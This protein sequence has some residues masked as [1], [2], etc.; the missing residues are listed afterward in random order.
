MELRRLRYFLVLA[1]EGHFGRAAR[2]LGIAQSALSQQIQVPERELDAQLLDR[3]SRQVTLTPAGE[4]LRRTAAGIL[5]DVER[6]VEETRAVARG[7]AGTL[8]IGHTRSAPDGAA[9]AIVAEFRRRYP[10]VDVT[11]ITGYTGRNVADLN[12]GSLDAAF[13]RPPLAASS[14]LNC[15]VVEREPLVVGLPVDHELSAQD[16]VLAEQIIGERIIGWPEANAPGLYQYV[17]EIL[18]GGVGPEV[19]V[20][21]PDEEHMARAVARGEGIAICFERKLRAIRVPGFVLRPFRPPVPMADLAL[22][23]R[24]GTGVYALPRLVS[25]A[26]R[27]SAELA[28][29]ALRIYLQGHPGVPLFSGHG[30]QHQC[31]QYPCDDQRGRHRRQWRHG[32]G[33]RRRQRRTVPGVTSR[34]IRSRGGRSRISAAR[35]ARSAQSSRGRGLA[36]R[37]TATSCRSTSSS[38]SLEAVGRA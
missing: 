11:L 23:W 24:D 27:W 29:L 32:E 34:C 21:E 5:R 7:R 13:V 20:E 38:A 33:Q 3:S 35:T 14:G 6:A 19:S 18:W 36:W 16:D 28:G 8:R 12:A 30:D 9:P 17:N 22:A 37:S 25:V 10:A 15:L 2:D 1:D 4:V 31:R 26:R